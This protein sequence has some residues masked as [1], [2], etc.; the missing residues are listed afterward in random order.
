MDSS[1]KIHRFDTEL[2]K[3]IIE[4]EKGELLELAEDTAKKLEELPE[5]VRQAFYQIMKETKTRDSSYTKAVF[6]KEKARKKNK[7]ART[8]RRKNR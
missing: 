5:S 6:N 4:K 7:A 3:E 8:A 1:G 2:E